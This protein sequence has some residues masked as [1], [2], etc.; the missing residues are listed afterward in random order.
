[1]GQG[2]TEQPEGR[3]KKGQ[4]QTWQ[5]TPLWAQ[6]LEGVPL[7]P[8]SQSPGSPGPLAA[9]TGSREGGQGW[10]QSAFDLRC[11]H[12]LAHSY[13]GFFVVVTLLHFLLHILKEQFD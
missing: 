11:Q 13:G 12:L 9:L 6:G 4:R 5:E 10:N 3:E 8:I 2:L 1:M 7:R